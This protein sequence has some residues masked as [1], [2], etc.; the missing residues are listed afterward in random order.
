MNINFADVEKLI[1]IAENAN[2]GEL[3]IT[4]GQQTIRITCQA[5]QGN[6]TALS[7]P[8]YPN[9]Q[10]AQHAQNPTDNTLAKIDNSVLTPAPVVENTKETTT[11]GTTITSPMVGTFYRKSSP[12]TPNFVEEGSQ[13]QANQTLCIIEAMK[14]MHEV[15]A[16]TAGKITAILVEEGA[17]VEYGEALFTISE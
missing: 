6:T 1:K 13:V 9:A 4:S 11:S 5:P 10:S 2:I 3:E 15:K 8:N 17:M 14:I 7:Q 16:E 12:D